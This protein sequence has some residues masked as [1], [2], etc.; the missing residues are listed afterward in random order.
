M[1]IAIIQ[2]TL[3]YISEV[4]SILNESNKYILSLILAV[5]TLGIIEIIG[6]SVVGLYL[7]VIS[8]EESL[9]FLVHFFPIDSENSGIFYIGT[10]LVLVYLVKC[11]MG[12]GLNFFIARYGFKKQTQLRNRLLASYSFGSFEDLNKTSSSVVMNEV[13]NYASSFT[14]NIAPQLLRFF[15]EIFTFLVLILYLTYINPFA[16]LVIFLLFGF[17]MVSYDFLFKDKITTSGRISVQQNEELMSEISHTIQSNREIRVLG[18][19]NYFL[20]RFS[21]QQKIIEKHQ[22]NIE[23]LQLIPRYLFEV[24][25]VL[26]IV[27]ISFVFIATSNPN[28]FSTL[29]MFVVAG[30]RIMPAI[31]NIVRTINIIRAT[32]HI[33]SSLNKTISVNKKKEDNKKNIYHH[34]TDVESINLDNVSYKYIET[35]QYILKNISL[36]IKKG[37]CIGISGHSGSGKSTLIG[38]ILGILHPTKGKALALTNDA[39]YNLS[40]SNSIFAYIPQEVF[41]IDDSIATN[42]AIGVEKDQI[43]INKLESS[44]KMAQIDFIESEKDFFEKKVGENGSLLSGGQRQRIALARMFY[45]ERDFIVLDEITSS[46][47]KITEQE[48]IK[49]ISKLK[50]SKTFIIVSHSSN[51]MDICDRVINLKNSTFTTL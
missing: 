8:G 7:G 22:I 46:L 43:D 12:Y 14:L 2:K 4:L 44:V 13:M 41:I 31:I 11:L 34:I 26:S 32:R 49:T 21:K 17:L 9:P 24:G 47:D 20:N 6:V 19:I 45:H 35:S 10:A 1:K 51:L 23:A 3:K 15:S 48:I 5:I 30:L 18:I 28:I 39:H 38:I 42:I 29:G 16:I 27:F 50:E 40:E 25:M 33:I 36:N 37:D